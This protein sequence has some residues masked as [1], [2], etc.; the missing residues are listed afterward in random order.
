MRVTLTAFAHLL[1]YESSQVVDQTYIEHRLFCVLYCIYFFTLAVY[2]ATVVHYVLN[3]LWTTLLLLADKSPY[4]GVLV[5][6]VYGYIYS[7]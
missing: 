4:I 5:F 3:K 1:V 6:A 2:T 7:K